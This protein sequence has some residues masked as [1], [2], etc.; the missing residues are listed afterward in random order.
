MAFNQLEVVK[1]K[2]TVAQPGLFSTRGSASLV[3]SPYEAERAIKQFPKILF[4]RAIRGDSSRHAPKEAAADT[5]RSGQDSPAS[6]QD[7]PINRK[8]C[9]DLEPQRLSDPETLPGIDSAL[10][11]KDSTQIDTHSADTDLETAPDENASPLLEKATP[12]LNHNQQ[13]K[14]CSTTAPEA[15]RPSALRAWW[16]VAK[17]SKRF[18]RMPNSA[19]TMSEIRT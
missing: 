17:K 15:L 11:T 8:P 10:T 18:T 3:S 13:Q 4:E 12:I 19:V 6:T 14:N 7:S 5:I 16:K 1:I 2:S 9:V